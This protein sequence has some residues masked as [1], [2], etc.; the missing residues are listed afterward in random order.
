M[1]R[2][3]WI[4]HVRFEPGTALKIHTKHQ[5]TEAQIREAI[6]LG[7][8]EQATFK[9]NTPYGPRLEVTGT[10]YDGTTRI[11]AWLEPIDREDGTWEC[12]TAV[13]LQ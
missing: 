8:H 7:R 12:K 4:G 10:A 2:R 6:T 11:K 1:M 5:L 13:R 3:E 9:E